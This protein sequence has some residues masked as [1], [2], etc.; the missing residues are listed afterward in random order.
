MQVII[1]F[2]GFHVIVQVILDLIDV[3]AIQNIVIDQSHNS[4]ELVNVKLVHGTVLN[5]FFENVFVCLFAFSRRQA[6]NLDFTVF[7]ELIES[8]DILSNPFR[9]LLFGNLGRIQL[10][11]SCQSFFGVCF[12]FRFLFANLE[13]F[14]FGFNEPACL[15]EIVLVFDITTANPCFN[16]ITKT[17]KLFNFLLEIHFVLFLL[18]LLVGLV[19]L[20]PN[21]IKQ[22]DTFVHLF[23][24]AI[25]FGYF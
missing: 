11:R 7:Q 9:R 14:H 22:G 21:F 10:F 24:D 13:L 1:V 4:L 18:I 20:F 19:D 16:L 2:V 3:F 12:R 23:H 15:N 5:V 8:F 25:N 17:L 6:F